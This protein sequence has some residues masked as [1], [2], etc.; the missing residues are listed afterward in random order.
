MSCVGVKKDIY[1]GYFDQQ[2][3][4]SLSEKR[5]SESTSGLDL[6]SATASIRIRIHQNCLDPKQRSI[7]SRFSRDKFLSQA[8]YLEPGHVR[9]GEGGAGGH[10]TIVVLLGH[11]HIAVITPK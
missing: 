9:Y 4:F 6:D 1:N 3:K 10:S 8:W 11:Q 7:L 2:Q 5:W